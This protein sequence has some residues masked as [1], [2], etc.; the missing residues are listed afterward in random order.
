MKMYHK[1]GTCCEASAE[2]VLCMVAGGWSTEKPSIKEPVVEVTEPVK[3][4]VEETPVV[5]PAKETT[6]KKRNVTSK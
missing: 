4:V 1:D 5:V 2:Q 3:S 6:A